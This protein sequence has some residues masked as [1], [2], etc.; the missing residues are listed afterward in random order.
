MKYHYEPNNLFGN[1]AYD[2]IPHIQNG[3]L[4]CGTFGDSTGLVS[5]VAV[6][7]RQEAVKVSIK[8]ARPTP[9]GQVQGKRSQY[10]KAGK[11]V[12]RPLGED[13]KIVVYH[14]CYR[15]FIIYNK[16]WSCINVNDNN[17]SE[18]KCRLQRITG[19]LGVWGIILS[20][21]VATHAVYLVVVGWESSTS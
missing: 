2:A 3:W 9:H 18:L 17:E 15:F 12:L 19:L 10:R 11:E 6:R 21:F 13:F 20:E 5:N 16:Q 1:Y 8:M 14:N 7:P 4:G